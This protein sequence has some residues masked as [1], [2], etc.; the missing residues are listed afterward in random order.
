LFELKQAEQ[1]I[2]VKSEEKT[3]KDKYIS[4]VDAIKLY[5]ISAPVFKK[6]QIGQCNQIQ[7]SR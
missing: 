4:Q 2:V 1:Q 3:S 6:I 7:A 5:D